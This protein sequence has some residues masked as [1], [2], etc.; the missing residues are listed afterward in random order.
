MHRPLLPVPVVGVGALC[1]ALL[2]PGSDVPRAGASETSDGHGCYLNFVAQNNSYDHY[3]FI[4]I[5][6]S[7]IRSFS[8]LY[9]AGTWAKIEKTQNQNLAPRSRRNFTVWA[10]LCGLTGMAHQV[11]FSLKRGADRVHS[12]VEHGG[13]DT[14]KS[15]GDINR[16][17]TDR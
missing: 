16:F 8:P 15:L 17:F 11:D 3:V 14:R 12:R 9:P 1:A 13:G 4:D 6:Q 2:L 10:K 7:R 5:E